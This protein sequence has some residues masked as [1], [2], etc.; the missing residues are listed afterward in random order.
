MNIF[1]IGDKVIYP[2]QGIGIIEDIQDEKY[3]GKNFISI[4]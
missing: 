1:F 4:I 2:N 3:L